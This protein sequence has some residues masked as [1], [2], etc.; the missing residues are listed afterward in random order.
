MA[1]ELAQLCSNA[2]GLQAWLSQAMSLQVSKTPP[3]C[4][5]FTGTAVRLRQLPFAP[6]WTPWS[7]NCH[8]C[9]SISYCMTVRRLAC[10]SLPFLCCRLGRCPRP[11]QHAL[12]AQPP[13]QP[14]RWAA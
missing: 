5:V 4:T 6:V 2:S 1:A 11:L 10:T 7:V 12:L 8:E 14:H 13:Q 9:T 3:L